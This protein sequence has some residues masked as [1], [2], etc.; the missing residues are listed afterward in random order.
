MAEKKYEAPAA[1][2]VLE[3]LEFMV[4]EPGARG[5][6]ELA[7]RLELTANLTFRILNVLS[8]KGYVRKN[9]GGQYELTAALFSLGMKLQ[10][11]FDLR[12]QARPFLECLAVETR[13]SVQI[14]VPDGD[15]MLQLDFVAPPAEYYQAVTPGSRIYWHGNAFGKAVW[16]FLPDGEADKIMALPRPQMNIHTVTEAQLI[17]RELEDIRRTYS[18]SEFEEYLLGNYCIG[19]PVFNATGKV[20]AGIGITGMSSRLNPDSIPGLRARV[21]SCAENISRSIGYQGGYGHEPQS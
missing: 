15:R 12:K 4:A 1:A 11:S 19:S 10:N 13:E 8:E 16:A 17:R 7:R 6:T 18:S 21:L 5:P 9:A 20:V 3:L 14:Q 2:A